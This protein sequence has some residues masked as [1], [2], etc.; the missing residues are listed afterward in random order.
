MAEN[1]RAAFVDGTCIALILSIVLVGY[2]LHPANRIPTIVF[3]VA[4]AF[5][6]WG[7]PLRRTALVAGL[8]ALAID[9]FVLPSLE[10]PPNT[11]EDL[12]FG[13]VVLLVVLLIRRSTPD[14]S[15][16]KIAQAEA[17]RTMLVA[18]EL[19]DRVANSLAVAGV[20]LELVEDDP[21]TRSEL[22]DHARKAYAR[23]MDTSEDIKSLQD[24]GRVPHRARAAA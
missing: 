14:L 8:S 3:F 11:V 21:D 5:C 9:H 20:V 6:A 2:V 19:A 13:V 24:V 1:R 15:A 23:I 16:V 18:G 4:I 7:T 10:V 17:E 12:L 22:R